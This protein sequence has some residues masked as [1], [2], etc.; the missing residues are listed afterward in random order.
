MYSDLQCTTRPLHALPGALGD[1]HAVDAGAVGRAQVAHQQPAVGADD[2]FGVLARYAGDIEHQVAASAAA[3]QISPGR[4]ITPGA[5]AAQP[6]EVVAQAHAR[7][8]SIGRGARITR[9]PGNFG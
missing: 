6:F 2:Q 1:A 3:E 9:L 4:E 5:V 8:P 7:I